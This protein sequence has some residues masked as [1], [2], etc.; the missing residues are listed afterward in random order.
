ML[1][2][3]VLSSTGCASSSAATSPTGTL[4][5]ETFTGAVDVGGQA[6]HPFTVAASG[7]SEA[8]VDLTT[9]GPPSTIFMGVGVGSYSNSVCTLLTNG[10]AIVQ[11]RATAQ[12]SGTLTGGSYCVMVYDAGNQTA[13]VSYTVVVTHY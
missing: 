6:A 1:G 2:A 5:T 12:L 9:A 7:S 10:Y 4:S 8:T 11:A 3:L 13:Q